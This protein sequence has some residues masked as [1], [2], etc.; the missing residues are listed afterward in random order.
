MPTLKEI[1][2]NKWKCKCGEVL[3]SFEEFDS[4]IRSCKNSGWTVYA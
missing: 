3:K 4:H 2:K 1:K